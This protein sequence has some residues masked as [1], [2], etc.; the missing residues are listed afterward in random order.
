LSFCPT[1][2]NKPLCPKWAFM[3]PSFSTTPISMTFFSWCCGQAFCFA[4]YT[5]T[6]A[7]YRNVGQQDVNLCAIRQCRLSKI[8]ERRKSRVCFLNYLLLLRKCAFA[9]WESLTFPHVCVFWSFFFF[10]Q[11][12]KF[13]V[14]FLYVKLGYGYLL[15]EEKHLCWKNGT[16]GATRLLWATTYCCLLLC[17]LPES[18]GHIRPWSA[19]AIEIM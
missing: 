19:L 16:I 4:C 3:L 13:F 14:L 10:T 8:L 7:S 15:E 17:N 2:F 12:I 11:K 9:N 5:V 6:I 1:S 18:C